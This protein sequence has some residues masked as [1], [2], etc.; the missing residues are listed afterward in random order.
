MGERRIKPITLSQCPVFP[1]TVLQGKS[2]GWPLPHGLAVH[3]AHRGKTQEA[4]QTL[5]PRNTA[6]LL[7]R[8]ME[9]LRERAL[10]EIKK[11]PI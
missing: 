7:H 8:V 1:G 5:S 10:D 4:Q 9:R 3:R 2:A 6:A 11:Q